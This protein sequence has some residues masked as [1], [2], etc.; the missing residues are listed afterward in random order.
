MALST[1]MSPPITTVDDPT[2]YVKL[3]CASGPVDAADGDRAQGAPTVTSM[4]SAVF[5][6][7]RP[8][9]VR[10]HRARRSHPRAPIRGNHLSNTTCITHVFFNSGE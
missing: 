5:A 2:A 10:R 8:Q 4:L 3:G 7:C 6:R 1:R 9:K